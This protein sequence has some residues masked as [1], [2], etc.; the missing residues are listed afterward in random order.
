M[1]YYTFALKD[2]FIS[3]GSS[4]ITGE[5]FK[6][7]NFGQD[8]ILE[9]KKEFFNDSF[10]Y[11]TRAL[12]QFDLT[13]ISESVADGT[14]TNPS[15]H[16]RLYEA[17]GNQEQT[18]E[19]TLAA[20][21]ISQSWDEGVG[22]STD[23]PKTINGCSFENR[24]NKPGISALSWSN[25]DGTPSN[26]PSTLVVS[27]STQ[28][29]SNQSPDV[30][31][32]ITD[33]TT[34]WITN[35]FSNYGLLLNFSGSEETDSTTFGQLK[36]FSKQ[37]HTIFSPKLEVRWDDHL[38]ATGSNTGSLSPLNVVGTEDNYLYV[39]RLK[40][41]Y[42]ETDKVKFRVGVRKRYIQ[43]TFSTSVQEA[44]QSFVPEGSGSYAIRDVATGEDIVPFSDFTKLSCDV[45]GSYFTQWLNTFE[46]NRVYKIM[47]KL[48][49]TDGNQQIFDEDFE[50]KV[51]R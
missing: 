48:K 29:F 50:F 36:F 39:K 24:I 13:T 38:P 3:S 7:Q 47:L 49:T 15:Y 8:Q 18:L 25:A 5:S 2:S 17:E 34:G 32:D 16:L 51:K 6:D 20:Q 31:M 19:Y 23:N 28:A 1:H 46:P 27:S 35:Q 4:N 45:S 11:P 43:K 33:M 21:V 37:T 30:E 10:D 40:E 14:I 42:K 22:K 41:E 26:G 9:V 44:S 12:V